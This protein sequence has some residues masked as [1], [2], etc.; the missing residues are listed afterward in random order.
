[1]ADNSFIWR[2]NTKD[3][4]YSFVVFINNYAFFDISFDTSGNLYGVSGDELLK[5]D[6]INGGLN[7]LTIF[8]DSAEIVA[9]TISAHNIIYLAGSYGEFYSYDLNTNV[10]S[11]LGNIGY[12]A[13]GDLTFYNG[14]LYMAAAMNRMIKVDIE[15]PGKSTFAFSYNISGDVYGIVSDFR[16]CGEVDCFAVADLQSPQN[17]SEIYKINFANRQ[18]EYVCTLDK[19]ST[20]GASTTEFMAS[21]PIK[22]GAINKTDPNCH[23]QDG[24][25]EIVNSYGFGEVMY[26][27]DGAAYQD[28]H[29][30]DGLSEGV[31]WV[32]M[33]NQLGCQDSVRIMLEQKPTPNIDSIFMEPAICNDS[34]GTLSILAADGSGD[35]TYSLD[36]NIFQDSPEFKQ[37]LPGPYTIWVRDSA[38]CTI[39]EAIDLKSISPAHILSIETTSTF[40]E[41][42]NGSIEVLADI[43]KGIEYSIDGEVFQ[44]SSYFPGLEAKN[45]LLVIK[46]SNG[47]I[48]TSS[49][50]IT[51]SPCSLYI[52]NVF[53]PNGDGINDIFDIGNF[54]LTATKEMEMSI[55][56]RWGN[57]VFFHH[58]KDISTPLSWDGSFDRKLCQVGV[59]T[60]VVTLFR[61]TEDQYV[62]R[63]TVT[64]IR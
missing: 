50:I 46:D 3:C 62:L 47:C 5:I 54:N 63:G 56:D 12:G 64:L 30:F 13:A 40:C 43:S 10:Q 20:G 18:L 9:M 11:Y 55:Y 2:L 25:I 36:G 48:D 32:R 4:S 33:I 29:V 31:Y 51:I 52:P 26:S 41:K 15:N 39:N 7:S 6:T 8:P 44:S 16:G 21:I 57:L 34:F 19:S 42:N 28:D 58:L 45:Y 38:G 24:R 14:E 17:H 37:L 1:M 59:Y 27:I 23:N 49:A 35:L 53:S 61:S 22:I 60:Y